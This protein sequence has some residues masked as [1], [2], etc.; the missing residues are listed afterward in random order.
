MSGFKP[1]L[2]T[3]LLKAR[4]SKVLWLTTLGFI[5][6]PFI[7]G[8]FM[9][10]LKNPEL[11]RNMGLISIKAQIVTGVADWPTFLDVF[12]QG[13]AVG[14]ILGF[15]LA[16]SWIFGREYSDH[17]VKDLLALPTSRSK[18]VLAKFV[19]IT[20]WIF[21]VSVLILFIGVAIGWI[22]VLPGWSQEVLINGIVR[23]FITT[24][25]TLSITYPVAFIASA[26]RGY[27]LPLGFAILML[28][29]AQIL[30]ATGWGRFFPWAVPS[31]YSKIAGPQSGQLVIISFLIVALTGLAGL[32]LTFYYWKYSDQTR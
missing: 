29:L 24:C 28:I 20:I 8:L 19:I 31:L 22:I 3:E 30:G 27:L 15:G 9:V 23:L 32:F 10:I 2:T 6:I 13:I 4:R 14:G 17:T 21:I 1:A 25:L 11:A 7:N 26:G 18:I 12:S 16:I 5:F